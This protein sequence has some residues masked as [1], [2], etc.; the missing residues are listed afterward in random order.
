MVT[1][2]TGRPVSNAIM[3]VQRPDGSR[4]WISINSQPVQADSDGV[5]QAV[6]TSFH[7][8][9]EVRELLEQVRS[10]EARLRTILDSS[11]LCVK[12]V[13]SDFRLLEINRAGLRLLDADP[14]D[15]TPGADVFLPLAPEYHAVFRQSVADA[16]AGQPSCIEYEVI[17]LR[18]TRRAIEQHA[19]P[20]RDPLR[21][22][23]ITAMLAVSFDVTERRTAEAALRESEERFRVLFEAAPFAVT[24]NAMD[25]PFAAVNPAFEQFSGYAAAEVLGRVPAEL[26]MGSRSG[27][28]E[29]TLSRLQRIGRLDNVEAV[30]RRKDGS[31][32]DCLFSSRVINVGGVRQILSAAIDITDRKRAEESLRTSEQ[33][34]AEAQRIAHV[35]NWYWDRQSDVISWS[36]EVYRIFG[37]P[38][39]AFAPRYQEEFLQ[40]VHPDDRPAIEDAVRECLRTGSPFSLEHLVCRPD[41]GERTVRELGEV[42]VDAMGTPVGMIGT[43][44]DITERTEAEAQLKLLRDELTHVARVGMLGELAAGIA[45]ELN[46]PLAAITNYAFTLKSRSEQGT[47]SDLQQWRIEGLPLLERIGEQAVRGGEIIRRLQALIRNTPSVRTAVPVEKLIHEVLALQSGDLRLAQ[48]EVDV[49]VPAALPQVLVDAIQIQQVLFNLIRN[50]IE[51]LRNQPANRR[52]G[53]VA[54]RES[55]TMLTI[56]VRD[57]GAGVSA[58]LQS[59]LFTPFASSKPQGLGLGLPISKRIVESHGGEI[60]WNSDVESGFEVRFSLP[61]AD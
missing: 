39:G 30:T 32:R 44:Q 13:D 19:V 16:F 20:L 14:E 55:E 26:G 24:L 35:G 59:R 10:R 23:V 11:P 21:P 51:S 31:V 56:C 37:F 27:D 29:S 38:P 58:E 60:Q 12:V 3:G 61:I 5:V 40:L 22:D 48:I 6:V 57:S 49:K 43:V 18:G 28:G 33:R 25:G 1:L 17:G 9:T 15:F 4:G 8:V 42:L 41:G 47:W 2:R 45:H 53:I 36:D 7:D 52:I 50:S 46:Q 34:L 54:R